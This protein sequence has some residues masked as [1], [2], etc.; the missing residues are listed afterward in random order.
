MAY[1]IWA[2]ALCQKS[3]LFW[4]DSVMAEDIKPENPKSSIPSGKAGEG[5]N[6]KEFK[7]LV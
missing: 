7:E 1:S 4:Q 6:P 5:F 2:L 3:I